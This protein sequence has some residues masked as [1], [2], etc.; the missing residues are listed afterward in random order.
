MVRNVGTCRRDDKG[1]LQAGTPQVGNTKIV[2]CKDGNRDK[3]YKETQFDFL[4]FTF[5]PRLAKNRKGH[6]FVSFSPALSTKAEVA[7]RDTIRSWKV[8][9]RIGYDLERMGEP[10][11]GRLSRTVL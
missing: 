6:F 9:T 5:R 11:D 10:Y 7:L 2:Y 1:K 4:G 3:E 8:H